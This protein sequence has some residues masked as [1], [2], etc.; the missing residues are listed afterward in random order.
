M[1]DAEFGSIGAL[2]R[3]LAEAEATI[4]ALLSNEIDAVVDPRTSSPVLLMNAQTAL[5]ES[6][7][8][9]RKSEEQYR[10]IVE[11]TSDGIVKIDPTA[12]VLFANRRFAEMLGYQASEV[13]GSSLSSLVGEAAQTALLSSTRK[14][15]S[16]KDAIDLELRH[17]N[18]SEVSVSV[19]E[20]LLLNEAGEHVGHLVVV[21]DVTEQKRLQSQLLVS[22]RMASVGTLAA[23]VAHEINNPLAAVIANLDYITEQRGRLL[24]CDL[25]AR[26]YDSFL[27]DIQGPL[28]DAAEAARRVRLIVRDLKVF[29]RSPEAEPRG[30]ISV[31]NVLESAVRMAWNELRHRARLVKDYE[32]VPAVEVDE[33][34]LVQVFLNLLVNSAQAIPE[35]SAEKNEVRISTRA[36]G[37]RVVVEVSDTGGGIQPSLISRIFDPFFTTKAVGV[38]TGLG[39]AICQRLVTD[40]GGELSVRSEMGKGTTFRV[41]LPIRHAV[42]NPV[43]GPPREALA[44]TRRGRILVVDDDELILRAVERIL[45]KEHDVVVTLG[46]RQAL[47][48]CSSGE[49]F[50]LIL[51]DLMMP[52]MTGMDVY[53]ELARVA[54]PQ[55][56]R[57]VFLTGG[58]FTPKARDFLATTPV[59]HIEKPFVASNLRAFVQRYLRAQRGS[60]F[61]LPLPESGHLTAIR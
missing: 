5:R 10:Q 18:G 59:E 41:A 23:G 57:V 17:K 6:E 43:S 36:T 2:T 53:L 24:A 29:S 58:A 1:N 35:G 56:E 16:V 49:T 34:R 22:D 14:H 38:G 40:M 3:R 27:S 7:K 11:A 20:T 28:E 46:A 52:D 32:P 9:L 44:N 51:C 21:R 25:P 48:L 31:V 26:S 45:S 13:V 30:P 33:A 54:P 39:L 12:R 8:W 61:P 47:A 55:E 4:Q 37:D 42:S 60:E 19:A 15:R 50:D